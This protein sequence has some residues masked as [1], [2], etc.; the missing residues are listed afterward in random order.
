M[1]DNTA[2]EWADATVNAVNGCKDLSV[3][4]P[5]TEFMT[6]VLARRFWTKVRFDGAAACWEWQS[7]KNEDGYGRFL[8]NGQNRFA[9][10]V[11]YELV[12]GRIPDG[13]VIDHLCRKR[14]CVNPMHMEPVT[15]RENA[16]RGELGL[17]MKERSA[18]QTHCVHGHRLTPGNTYRQ[19]S[20]G[21]RRCKMCH[22][23]NMRR[24]RSIT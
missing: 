12:R 3:P 19:P 23:L 15:P 6:E 4:V 9:H 24:R 18:A 13:L 20:T 5:I 10:R 22:R 7:C 1:S 8:V 14:D 11:S 21:R 17:H 2:I 16:L